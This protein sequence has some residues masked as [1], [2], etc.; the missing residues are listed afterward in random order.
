ME[1]ALSTA[2]FVSQA[3]QPVELTEIETA[4]TRFRHYPEA[5][6]PVTERRG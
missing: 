4:L 5:G 2:T 1:N 6:A 3:S